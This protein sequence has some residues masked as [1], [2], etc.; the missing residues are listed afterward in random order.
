M[1]FCRCDALTPRVVEHGR[2]F[3]A[4]E[5]ADLL[6]VIGLA[7]LVLLAEVREQERVPA[8]LVGS[9]AVTPSLARPCIS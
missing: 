5:M 4:L 8:R 1:V 7:V 6:F 2:K 9:C 3:D